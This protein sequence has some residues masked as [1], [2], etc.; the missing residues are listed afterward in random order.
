M[1]EHLIVDT[2]AVVDMMRVGRVTPPLL[3]QPSIVVFLPLPVVGELITGAYS[4][5][6]VDR[7]LATTEIV[8]GRWTI[9]YPD[10]HT[11]RIYGRIRA[12]ARLLHQIGQS[13]TNDLW[14][15]ALCVQYSLPLLTND[16]GFD[17]IPGLEV[18]H[19]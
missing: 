10:L 1:T 19:W 16:Q 9:L 3:E 5:P 14:I 8:I 12:Q 17:R 15:A 2:N 11:A 6:A 4:T 7:N 13:L 18:I